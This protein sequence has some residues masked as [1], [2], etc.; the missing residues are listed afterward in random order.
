M[1]DPVATPWIA[2][3][4]ASS[5]GKRPLAVSLDGVPLVLF[6]SGGKIS[7]LTDLCPHRAAP[8]S[9]GRVVD[10][11]IECPYHGWQFDGEGACR[12]IPGACEAIPRV[13]VATHRAVEAGGLVFVARAATEQEPYVS[14]ATGPDIVSMIVTNRTTSTVAE[15][16]ENILDAHHT[17]FVH[18]GLLRG[19]STRRYRNRVTVTGGDGWVEARYEG[20]PRQEGLISRLLEGSRTISIGRFLYPGIAELEFWGPDGLKLV[21]TFHL[22]NAAP[23]VVEGLGL[24]AAPKQGGLGYLKALL[25]RPL[26]ELAV[27][28]DQAILD[29]AQENRSKFPESRPCIG[30]LDVMRPHIDAI[31]AGRRPSVAD[32]P[33]TLSMDL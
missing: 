15:A 17:H 3:A 8:L 1:S 24:L 23:G 21:T 31:L 9:R 12:A 28:Q 33:L 11:A 29:M 26:F 2:V 20:E 16:A 7:C 22:R 10:G 25:F 14:A 32:A 18:K 19:L 5:L 27:R 4:R 13:R 6:R 30:P